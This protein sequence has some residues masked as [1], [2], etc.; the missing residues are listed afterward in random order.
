MQNPASGEIQSERVRKDRGM[1]L[2]SRELRGLLATLEM[3]GEDTAKGIRA[4]AT[5]TWSARLEW[6]WPARTGMCDSDGACA[7]CLPCMS[8]VLHVYVWAFTYLCKVLSSPTLDM[9]S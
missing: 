6:I 7:L 2:E 5:A 8:R 4:W 9:F 1:I 3:W